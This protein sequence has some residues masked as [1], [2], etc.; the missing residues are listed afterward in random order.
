MKKL[1]F[2]ICT[3]ILLFRVGNAQKIRWAAV[4]GMTLAQVLTKENGTSNNSDLKIGGSFGIAMDLPFDKT[5]SFQPSLQFQQ[6][7]GT[8]TSKIFND[9]ET[10]S[11]TLNYLS[12]PLNFIYHAPGKRGHFIAGLGP[13][14]SY[15][16][17]GTIKAS[18]NDGSYSS[19]VKFGSSSNDNL[20]AFDAG[21]NMLM[22]CEWNNG[23]FFQLNYNYSFTNSYT[24]D[25]QP[26]EPRPAWHN[27][28]FGLSVGYFFS[29]A[30]NKSK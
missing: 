12:I 5:F 18:S 4:G 10:V 19:S 27:E 3:C 17:G 8:E 20:V 9:N 16:L 11:F 14:V 28:Y 2:T 7:G 23:M 22:G 1:F 25:V 24:G 21:V 6:K 15:G 26:N 29:R 13:S 30:G